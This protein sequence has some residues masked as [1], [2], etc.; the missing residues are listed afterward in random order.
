[1]FLAYLSTDPLRGQK[2][3]GPIA[4]EVD[5]KQHARPINRLDL[6][7][8][9]YRTYR[10]RNLSDSAVIPLSVLKRNEDILE[11][12]FGYRKFDGR[13]PIRIIE[14]LTILANEDD[15]CGL[16]E[17]EAYMCL[18]RFLTETAETHYHTAVHAS[19]GEDRLVNN[20][21]TACAYLLKRY[22]STTAIKNAIQDLRRVRQESRESE[23]E[24]RRGSCL[25]THGQGTLWI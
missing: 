4:D 22:A 13:D 5:A 11:A 9:N 15:K 19:G 7:A 17:Q 21:P 23:E 16:S 2:Q 1:M 3:K 8:V 24:Y 20:W 25:R 18:P 10:V 12:R 14:F 6:H